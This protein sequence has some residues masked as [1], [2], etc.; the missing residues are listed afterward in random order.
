MP[1][2]TIYTSNKLEVLIDRLASNLSRPLPSVFEKEII[3]TQSPGMARWIAM[4]LAARHHISANTDYPFPNAFLHYLCE[5]LSIETGPEDIFDPEI[6]AFRIMKI[7]P[8]C[9]DRT[10]YASLRSYFIDDDRQIKQMQ[11]SGQIADLFDQ[12]LVFRPDMIFAWEKGNKISAGDQIWQADLWRELALGYENRHRA[13]LHAQIQAV[14]KKLKPSDLRLPERISIFGISYLPLFHLQIMAALSAVVKIDMY[15]LNPCREYWGEVLSDRDISR[16]REK[17]MYQSEDDPDLHLETGNQLLASLGSLGRDFLYSVAAHEC[18][19][20]EYY[21]SIERDNLLGMIQSDILDMRDAQQKKD[22]RDDIK[23]LVG[24]DSISIHA[25]HSTMREI[26]ILHD[27]I[28]DMLEQNSELQ[29]VDI[30]VMTPDIELYAPIIQAVFEKPVDGQAPM[31]FS[32]ADRTLASESRVVEGF[33]SLLDLTENRREAFKIIGLLDY[34]MIRDKFDLNESDIA[35]VSR[36]IQNLNIRWGVDGAA[37]Q[38]LGLPL[39]EE[40]TWKNG[41]ERLLLGY[42]MSGE[43]ETLYGDRL[44]YNGPEGDDARILGNF[45]AYFA[46]LNNVLEKFETPKTLEKWSA[47]L[48]EILDCLFDTNGSSQRELQILKRLFNRLPEIQD[49]SEFDQTIDFHSMVFYLKRHLDD[50]SFGAGFITGG[51]TF[52]AMLPMR[53]IPFKVICLIGMNGDAFP[54]DDN[55]LGFDLMAAHPRLGDRSR[56]KDDKYLFLEALI[57]A[58]QKLHIS[59]IGKDIQDN[60]T[61]EPCVLVSELLDYIKDAYGVH[62]DGIV[63]QHPLQAFSNRYF[64]NTP[65]LFSYS[66]ENFDAVLASQPPQSS[67]TFIQGSLPEPEKSFKTLQTGTLGAFFA[68][69]IKYFMQ[70]RLGI[71]LEEGRGVPEESEYFRL[72]GLSGYQIGSESLN[73][74]INGSNSV[75][76]LPLLQAK[77]ALPPGR[78]GEHDFAT[79][80]VET[81]KLVSQ[82]TTYT[83]GVPP[84]RLAIDLWIDDFNING[85]LPNLFDTGVVYMRYAKFNARDL[86][87]VWIAHLQLCA[88]QRHSR[89]PRSIY[90]G[91]DAWAEF[92]AVD[93]T[94]EILSYLLQ[95]F[96]QGLSQ[97]LM[98]LPQSA[99]AYAEK[100]LQK[101]ADREIA[102]QAAMGVMQGNRFSP[103]EIAEPY[104]A[105]CLDGRMSL[106]KNFETISMEIFKPLF[107]HYRKKTFGN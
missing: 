101:K 17:Y 23:T 46:C 74:D 13:G 67:S 60:S 14:I 18:D 103:G 7:L 55:V 28:L 64:N 5:K 4:Q 104:T 77:G 105:F 58:R 47:V 97:P 21:Q 42:A 43:P 51:V 70:K 63:Q 2:L 73:H 81:Q 50:A 96:W 98:F 86:L 72:G 106:D 83:M 48:L 76:L 87:H 20:R 79:V 57:S 39:F 12:Y 54:R 9:L 92:R 22:D 95:L 49:I 1:G 71:F 93:N 16:I 33:F 62:T 34:A 3:V 40:N 99:L 91:K 56:K 88:A 30:L 15:L 26:E 52:C 68:N 27:C 8:G 84:S 61:I 78:V 66:K 44:P 25:C 6:L 41:L 45:M 82:F 24:D 32:V 35:V 10:A 80:A 102:I 75:E 69:P 31:P 59:Y 85:E 107:E 19:I 90:L 94:V 89:K 100:R 53:S 37:R 29:P 11:L 38:A 65:D 36:W